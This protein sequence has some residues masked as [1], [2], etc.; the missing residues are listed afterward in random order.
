MN[1]EIY[2]SV[3]DA[4]KAKGLAV[5]IDVLRAFSTEAYVFANGAE[6]IIP[7]L[8][9]EESF[10]LKKEHPEYIL[11]GEREGKM[12]EGFDYGNSPA[13]IYEVDFT[14]K[15]VIHTTSNG[16]RGL[17]NAVNADVV[18]AGSLVM[19]KSIVKYFKNNNFETLSLVSTSP[20][21]D[22]DNEDVLMAYY[23]RDLLQGDSVDEQGIKDAILG[24]PARAFLMKEAGARKIDFDLCLD[25]N[26]F[27][28]VIKKVV[29]DGRVVLRKVSCG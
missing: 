25:F 4:E 1:I 9:L 8:T 3:D 23:V 27:D 10:V 2:K 28:F 18:L 13:E 20:Y 11:M 19:A 24:V 5:I 17:V 12:V 26:R 14:G 21:P 6:K 22:I 29:E 7:M 15:T 16:T